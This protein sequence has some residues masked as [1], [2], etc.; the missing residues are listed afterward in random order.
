LLAQYRLH[1]T[2][3]PISELARYFASN[4]KIYLQPSSQYTPHLIVDRIPWR[5]VYDSAT[6]FPILPLLLAFA[7]LTW[8]A[9]KRDRPTYIRTIGLILPVAAIAFVSIAFERG[10]NMRFKFFL[11]PVAFCFLAVQ[12]YVTGLRA[13]ALR[14][15]QTRK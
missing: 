11:E 15:D 12:V 9:R 8:I 2:T 13:S 1:I 4:S 14:P 5:S 6:S 7:S 10:E 3:T